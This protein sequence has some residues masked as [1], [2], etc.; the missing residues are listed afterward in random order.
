[1]KK[2]NNP[3]WKADAAFIN[4]MIA[5]DKCDVD[6][7]VTDSMSLRDKL[8]RAILDKRQVL[9]SVKKSKRKINKKTSLESLERPLRLLKHNKHVD[10]DCQ[11][12]LRR[13][14]LALLEDL[15][16]RE[17]MIDNVIKQNWTLA[18]RLVILTNESDPLQFY[19]PDEEDHCTVK[20]K[21]QDLN[22]IV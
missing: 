4:D 1:M 5:K 9:T 22:I 12:Y 6:Q 21:G 2:Q 20:D 15:I 3:P 7:V 17:K 8:E 11:D 13:L 16:I 14:N 19:N 10:F 18:K